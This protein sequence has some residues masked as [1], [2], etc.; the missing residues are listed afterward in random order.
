MCSRSFTALFIYL[1][2]SARFEAHLAVIS[3]HISQVS[4]ELQRTSAMLVPQYDSAELCASCCL[5]VVVR[6]LCAILYY[7]DPVWVL[8]CCTLQHANSVPRAA[9]LSSLHAVCCAVWT[10]CCIVPCFCC[11][12]HR[13]N[14]LSCQTWLLSD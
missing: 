10:A 12:D 14:T 5:D 1:P 4:A 13:S 9:M 11:N 8:L 7:A 3:F 2:T 6:M